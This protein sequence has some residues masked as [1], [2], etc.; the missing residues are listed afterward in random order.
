MKSVLVHINRDDGQEARF[1]TALDVVRAF[2]G[3]LTCLQVSP[4][5][6]FASLDPYGVSY[7]LSE[8]VSRIRE[9]SA[10]EQ[11]A[12]EERLRN[13]GLTWDWHSQTGD[14]VRLIGDHSWLAD[15][16]ILSSPGEDWA[17]DT[18]AAVAVRSRAPVLVVPAESRG[19]DCGGPVAIAWN[20]SAES[21]VAIRAAMPLLTRAQAVHLLT[22]AEEDEFDF[23]ATE[24]SAYLSRHGV[25]SELVELPRGA[26]PISDT[27][28]HAA[29]ARGTTCLVMGAY[30]HSRLR[31][32]ILG[33]VTRG[34]LQ[35]SHI[36]LLL[37]H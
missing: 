17:R 11:F 14:P 35:K 26:A 12:F 5:E 7:L 28:L 21:C 36:P 9:L 20:G 33:G 2:E 24:A 32:N 18:A 29:E 31:E 30:G 8:T 3:H 34:M 25:A 1:Q 4:L 19:F 27:L 10:E 13:E 6:A 37:A 16:V 22:V 23:P 15:L